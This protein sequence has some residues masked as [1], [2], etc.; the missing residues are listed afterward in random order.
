MKKL[1]LIPLVLVDLKI[2]SC[3]DRI[4]RLLSD[5]ELAALRLIHSEV[6]NI[7]TDEQ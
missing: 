2:I 6:Q 1:A 5:L 7:K 3:R 4:Y